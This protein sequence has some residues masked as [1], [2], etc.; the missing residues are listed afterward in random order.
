MQPSENT[1]WLQFF[2]PNIYISNERSGIS[3]LAQKKKYFWFVIVMAHKG[4]IALH[5]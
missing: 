2:N 3:F 4:A 5:I 1:A